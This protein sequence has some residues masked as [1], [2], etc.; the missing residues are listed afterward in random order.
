MATADAHELL[1]RA[2]NEL[3]HCLALLAEAIA[4][5]ERWYGRR[6]AELAAFDRRAGQAVYELRSRHHVGASTT[7]HLAERAMA[8]A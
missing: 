1:R 3:R 4:S 8:R 7:W 2:Q 5:A 6:E